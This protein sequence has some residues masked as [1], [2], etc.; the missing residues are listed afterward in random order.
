VAPTAAENLPATQLVQTVE[1]VD[2]EYSPAAH[3]SVHALAPVAPDEEEYLPAAHTVHALAPDESEYFPAEH[4]VQLL[5]PEEEEYDPR[6][7]SC[8]CPPV[9][10]FPIGHTAPADESDPRGQ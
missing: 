10:Y 4:C 1:P 5:A 2:A 7:Q 8:A 6:A 9:Q 3:T